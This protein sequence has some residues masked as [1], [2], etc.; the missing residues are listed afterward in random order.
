MTAPALP[1]RHRTP[2]IV[3]VAAAAG[4]LAA[5]LWITLGPVPWAQESLAENPLGI[6]NPEAWTAR[7]TWLGGRPLEFLMNVAMFVPLGALAAAVGRSRA[8]LAAPFALT[9][10]IELVQIALPDRASDPRDLVANALGAVIGIV[11]A[12]A[13]LARRDADRPR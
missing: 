11:I 1:I 9:V 10:G 4:Y 13:W 6:L 5:V 12:R 3:T 7:S 8:L 2:G